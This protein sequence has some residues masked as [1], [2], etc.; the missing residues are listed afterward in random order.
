MPIGD[1]FFVKFER[2]CTTILFMIFFLSN[3]TGRSNFNLNNAMYLESFSFHLLT[4]L[5]VLHNE[6]VKIK[7]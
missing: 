5:S 6:R 4:F 7:S 1:F 2:L 3:L